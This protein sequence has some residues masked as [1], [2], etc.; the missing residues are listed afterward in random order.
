MDPSPLHAASPTVRTHRSGIRLVMTP[1]SL[2]PRGQEGMSVPV[3]TGV[4][5][6]LLTYQS[7][8]EPTVSVDL[9]LRHLV[10]SSKVSDSQGGAMRVKPW[11]L[12]AVAT[13]AL[14]VAVPAAAGEDLQLT[15][16]PNEESAEACLDYTPADA[17]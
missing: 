5:R 16:D 4:K 8:W 6:A 9:K 7:E 10:R 3:W 14:L 11:C 2:W 1:P 12:L 17:E 15:V 13:V